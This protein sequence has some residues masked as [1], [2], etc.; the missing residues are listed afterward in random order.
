MEERVI[1]W[2]CRLCIT[3][4]IFLL[5]NAG[6]F[7][8]KNIE[9]VTDIDGNIYKIVKV[10][11]QWWMTSNLKTTR[12]SNGDLIGT[13]TLY[14]PGRAEKPLLLV[15]P[16]F[17]LCQKLMP[18]TFILPPAIVPSPKKSISVFQSL[19]DGICHPLGQIHLPSVAA[20]Q[21]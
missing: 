16:R 17:G 9:T 6:A 10:G 4:F 19:S 13:T 12:Y 20:Y 18:V 7:G 1:R 15:A 3:G 21:V 11:E 2:I 14:P 8:Q 5:S